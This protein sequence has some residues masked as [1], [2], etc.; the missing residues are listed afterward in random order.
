MKK[1]VL[2]LTLMYIFVN[3]CWGFE[4]VPDRIWGSYSNRS[5]KI[6]TSRRDYEVLL[7]LQNKQYI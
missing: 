1:L 4:Y 7:G 6:D 5:P 2:L 3:I